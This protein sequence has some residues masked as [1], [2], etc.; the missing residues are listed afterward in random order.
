VNRTAQ[1]AVNAFANYARMFVSIAAVAVLT[2]Y[3][4]THIGKDDFG[5]W[6]LV[7]SALGLLN[8]LDLGFGTGVVKYVAQASAS[9]DTARRNRVLSTLGLVYLAIS[10]ASLACVVA[11]AFLFNGVFG[12]PASQQQN[13]NALLWILSV[14]FVVLALPLSLFRNALYG[15]QKVHLINALQVVS[16]AIYAGGSW[17]VLRQGYGVI[18]LAWINLA[19]MLVEYLGYAWF[20]YAKMPGLR[21]SHRLIDKTILKETAS[22]SSAQFLINI[23][24]LICRSPAWR[25]TL[26]RLRSR[27][28]Y[29]CWRSS[30]RTCSGRWRRI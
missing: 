8:L 20:A 29:I 13:C 30:L 2:P 18:A 28:T 15:E 7:I 4:I 27:K 25:F 24:A 16:T 26:S 10:L 19:A 14:R 6:S 17:L 22:F 1:F 11:L 23:A 12:I 3:I 5:L 21:V 9:G